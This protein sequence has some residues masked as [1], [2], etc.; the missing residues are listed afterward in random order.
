MTETNIPAPRLPMGMDPEQV[1]E[2]VRKHGTVYP[3]SVRKDEVT[4]TGL[5]KKPTLSIM[6]AAAS[7]AGSDP[8]RSGEVLYKNCK[9]VADPEMD[10]DE[11]VHLAA[12]GGVN[13]LFRLLEAEVGE[14][15][16]V[17]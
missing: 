1:R 14:P 13:R 11:E 7:A 12:I 3:V 15:L 17:A 16:A 4:Y 2:L 6:S 10:T 9:L 8:L 5:F